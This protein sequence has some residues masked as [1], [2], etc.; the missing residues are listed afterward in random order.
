MVSESREGGLL[1]DNDEALLLGALTF[2][3][4]SVANLI[5]PPERV[6]TLPQGVTA[7][8]AE[9]AAVEGFSRFPVTAADGTLV[10]YVHI[11]DLLEAAADARDEPIP[12]A[13]IRELPRIGS[14]QPLRE[15]LKSMQ[16]S[17][18]PLGA[19]TDASGTALGI[20]TLAAPGPAS[21]PGS[22]PS[23][24]CGRRSRAC[25]PPAPTSAPP[26]TRTAP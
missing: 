7:A 8:Q 6:A 10:G 11:K 13:R 26:P 3:A 17:G 2:E 18:A 12:S 5:I 16:A 19:A 21:F 14:E 4:R 24:R 25:R 20:A 9:T 23:S 22:A 1:E 15:A